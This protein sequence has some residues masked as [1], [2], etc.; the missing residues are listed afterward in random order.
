MSCAKESTKLTL[1]ILNYHL[2]KC[3]TL[4]WEWIQGY[5]GLNNKYRTR[6]SLL[7]PW[8]CHWWPT[9]IR[10]TK[11]NWSFTRIIASRS[12]IWSLNRPWNI[13]I[14]RQNQTHYNLM[15][16]ILSPF[17]F[18]PRLSCDGRFA[19][20]SQL[21]IRKGTEALKG[22][23]SVCLVSQLVV[24]RKSLQSFI[25]VTTPCWLNTRFDFWQCTNI[26]NFA[27]CIYN[28]IAV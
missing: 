8:L 16:K 4:S 27:I 3:R 22:S 21:L 17:S 12:C 14:C 28:N 24:K 9:L 6:F 18:Q 11:Q 20:G 7:W 25:F 13:K 10:R 23:W 15:P 19:T 26:H 5:V 2:Q 1:Q